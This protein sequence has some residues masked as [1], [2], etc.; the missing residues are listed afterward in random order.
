MFEKFLRFFIDHA[1]IN[2]LLFF[3]IFIVGIFAYQK[4]PKEIFPSFDLDMISISGYYSG[5]SIDILDKMAVKEIEDDIRNVDGISQMTTVITPGKFNI[6]LELDKHVDRYNT[7]DKIK[8]AL[9]LSTQNLPSD[10]QVPIVKVIDI[11]RDLMRVA[12]SS[13]TLSHAK[14]IEKA[15]LL[16]DK[17]NKIKNIAEVSIYSDSDIYYDVVIDSKKL[18]ALG[19]DEN[20]VYRAVS[21]LS[22]IYPLGEI[23]DKK[24]GFYYLS[25]YN[26]PKDAAKMLQSRLS[27]NGNHFYLKD[28]ASVQK[29]YEDAASLFSIDGKKAVDIAIKQSPAGNALTLS[30]K[31]ETLVASYNHNSTEAA[32]TI[33]NDKSVHIK[34]RLNIIISNI[35][36][37]LL[38]IA[39]LVALLINTRMAFIIA[40]GI[41]TSFVLGAFYLYI[42]GYTI[43]MITLVGVLI[44]LGI[45]VDDAIVVSENIQQHIEEGKA[46]KEAAILG[47]SQMF[48]PVTVA[49]LT[50]LFAFIPALMISGT[51]GEV[52]KLI[53]I[54]VSVL[55]LASLIESFI[56]L[57]IH[58]A[59]TLKKEVKTCS[60]E[61][62]NHIYSRLIHYLMHYK[63]TFLILFVIIVPLLSIWGIKKS[64]FQMFPRF[65]ATTINVA[66]KAPVNTTTQQTHQILQ[67]I[68]Q[69]LYAH[70]EAFYIA[71]V[72]SVS[73]W[74]M[75][76]A[77]SSETYPYVGQIL[78]ELQKLKPQNF[79]DRF[80]TPNLSFYY[81]SKG[82]TRTEKSQVIAKKL[83]TF[84]QNQHYKKRF[85]LTD[86]DIVERK[87][88]PIKSDIKIGL[89][90]N[91]NTLIMHAM[92]QLKQKLQSINGITT[93]TEGVHF[94][95]DEIKLKLNSYGTSL[96]LSEQNLGTLLSHAYLERKSALI[97]DEHNLL[98]VKIR[99]A[100]K[101][102]LLA[103]ENYALTL[104]NG[105]TVLLKDV[106]SFEHKKSFEKIIKDFG[107]KNFYLYANVDTK[108]ITATEAVEKLQPLLDTIQ[109]KGI[110]IKLKGED[111]KKKELKSDMLAASTVAMLLIMLSL[112]YL[113]NSFRETFMMLSVIPFS[114]LGVLIGHFILGLNLSMSSVIGMLGLSGIVVNDGIIMIMN[115]KRAHNMQEIYFYAA[116]RFRP[117]IL[118]SLTTLI[119]LSSLIFFPTGQAAIFQPM[120]IALGFGLA[121]GTILNLLYLPALFALVNAKKLRGISKNKTF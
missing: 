83:R 74:R 87:V 110:Q 35:L 112:L 65:D 101:D 102:S 53:P 41:P 68:E 8:D 9:A 14:L 22:Y 118:T 46:P 95:I 27:I 56:F 42:S 67:Q 61:K 2:Y 94:G 5:A 91:D 20:A 105:S 104:D 18:T 117:I 7:A 109:K 100:D 58:A 16:K 24:N 120:A 80:I 111:E 113:F 57:P 1:R 30:G 17:I 26:G 38:L 84:L 50:T 116:K 119:G 12:L 62:A 76:A 6:I 82:R 88:G 43:N 72:G 10:M 59:H 44:A 19:L 85:H 69:D 73:G 114:F 103:L 90:N 77:G 48:K 55:V 121:W 64:K 78:I 13:S 54:A 70:K 93:I 40:L 25:T 11:K 81:D 79:V 23:E 89:V 75:D 15:N 66:L 86:I 45:I 52:M 34:D 115:L 97:F 108:I 51:M 63:K 71:H 99:S 32:Y 49:S 28:I 98:E 29:R 106:V 3:L 4:T 107:E 21:N 33:H 36:L 92:H 96:G 31:I 39:L 47:A 60:W 37:G